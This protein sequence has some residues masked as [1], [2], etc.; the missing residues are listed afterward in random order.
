[1]KKKY[2]TQIGEN[3]KDKRVKHIIGIFYNDFFSPMEDLYYEASTQTDPTIE[4]LS[5]SSCILFSGMGFN[6]IGLGPL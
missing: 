6:V 3:K 2:A 5:F 4:N 1:M